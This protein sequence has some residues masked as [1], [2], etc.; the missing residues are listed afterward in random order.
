MIRFY[1]PD[2]EKSQVL[3]ESDSQH[4]ARVLRMKPGTEIEVVDG[5]G[6]LFHCRLLTAHPHHCEVEILKRTP[7][8]KSWACEITVAV[9]PTKHNDRMEWLTEKLVET[10]VDRIITVRCRRSERK[11]IKTERLEK[12]AVSAMKQSLKALLPEIPEITSFEKFVEDCSQ[13]PDCVRK[14]IAYCDDTI[15]RKLL[16]KEYQ[17]GQDAIILIGP[18]GDFSTEEIQSAL[19]AGFEPVSLGDNRLRTETAAL[20]A[21][22]T[23]HIINQ[24]YL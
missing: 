3:P 21:A 13:K 1:C 9:A 14:F 6:N 10:G 8:P 20:M 16:A 15:E 22:N 4:C 18:E 19:K 24:R 12:I 5:L 7:M 17:P 23:C 2:I 11:D